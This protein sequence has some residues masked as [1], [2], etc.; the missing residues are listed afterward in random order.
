MDISILEANCRL[1]EFESCE[2]AIESVA[3]FFMAQKLDVS[4]S[5]NPRPGRHVFFERGPATP[6][7]GATEIPREP[8]GQTTF[9]YT[10]EVLVVTTL[11]NVFA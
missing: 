6:E 1:N 9:P 10:S 7:N 3:F 5:R 4:R 8:I 2:S 11:V